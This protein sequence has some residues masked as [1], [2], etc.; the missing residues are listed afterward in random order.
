MLLVEHG[1]MGKGAIGHTAPDPRQSISHRNIGQTRARQ[2]YTPPQSSANLLD[3]RI[4]S[5]PMYNVLLIRIAD[6]S[7]SGGQVHLS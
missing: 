4:L 3:G 7:P 2:V 1:G 5:F 6:V